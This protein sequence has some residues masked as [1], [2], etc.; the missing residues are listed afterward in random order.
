MTGDA[1][2]FDEQAQKTLRA[3]MDQ[4]KRDGKATDAEFNLFLTTCERTR[5]DPFARQIYAIWRSGRM[6]IQVSIDGFR[7]IA[8]RTGHYAGQDGP[9][10]CGPDGRWI[11]IWL[12]PEPPM[13]AKVSVF[14]DDFKQPL[15]AVA[16]WSAYAQVDRSGNY[17]PMW[18]RFGDVML[19]KVAEALALRRACPQEL[20][21]LYTTDEMAQAD[22]GHEAKEE[23]SWT[24]DQKA[25]DRA[26][27]VDPPRRRMESEL[28]AP[29]PTPPPWEDEEPEDD[30]GSL[31]N[32]ASRVRS[33][34]L[35]QVASSRDT[36]SPATEKQLKLMLRSVSALYNYTDEDALRKARAGLFSYVF[37]LDVPTAEA[38]IEDWADAGITK[39]Q[40][41]VLI[42]WALKGGDGPDKWDAD[43]NAVSEA[44][45]IDAA[46]GETAG[47]TRMPLPHEADLSTKAAMLIGRCWQAYRNEPVPDEVIVSAVLEDLFGSTELDGISPNSVKG[48][49]VTRFDTDLA[50]DVADEI[51]LGWSDV[52]EMRMMAQ[53]ADRLGSPGSVTT[54]SGLG[55][56]ASF[57]EAWVRSQVKAEEPEDEPETEEIPI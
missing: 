17:T 23:P 47:Q 8:E 40:A 26:V 1:M 42:D 54:T 4:D 36:D 13:G 31:E 11:D 5:L 39:A 50:A 48:I 38:K 29:A 20:S 16:R 37:D 24:H 21:G 55:E 30:L 57:V 51:G 15:T 3:Q 7:L 14:R 35:Q 33:R 18:A 22:N 2:M 52:L 9:W 41:T 43:S 45:M 25:R 56:R 44:A 27:P 46:I 53:T 49:I 12:E 10:W 6:S 32:R 34:L 28:D 19:A